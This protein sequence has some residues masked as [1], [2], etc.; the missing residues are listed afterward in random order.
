MTN[1]LSDMV[2]RRDSWLNEKPG[3]SG[4]DNLRIDTGDIVWN[5]FIATGDDGDR[6]IK[7]YR[8]HSF[9]AVNAKGQR[10]SPFRYCPRANG[11]A[12]ECPYCAQGHTSIKERMSMWFW[13]PMIY[14][15]SVRA[16][17]TPDKMPP[18]I[19]YEGKT[20]F[21]E[22]VE[23]YKVW[24]TSAWKNSPLSDIKKL[25]E[26]YGTLHGFAA[27]LTR[28]GDG[29]DTLYKL[30]ALPNTP[31]MTSVGITQEKYQEAQQTLKPIMDILKEELAT[32][33]AINPAAPQAAQQQAPQPSSYAPASN[34][35]GMP[36]TAAQSA[37]PFATAASAPATV[38]TPTTAAASNPFQVTGSAPL[39]S[40]LPG[41]PPAAAV[42][43]APND[44]PPFEPTEVAP[45]V[46]AKPDKLP[47]RSL[48]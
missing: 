38:P 23:A 33:I 5:Q 24:H 21:A 25:L 3:F 28:S 43:E 32:P 42:E 40:F 36:A 22:T 6:F 27:Q 1:S 46:E 45:P 44:D 47:G 4:N 41:D 16:G 39:S 17:T 35:F 7:V 13:V 30:Y 31:N 26:M 11:D 29:M 2:A 14:R 9:Q 12:E 15:A 18:A 20:M 37:N 34:P 19:M 10:I 8:A 48:F